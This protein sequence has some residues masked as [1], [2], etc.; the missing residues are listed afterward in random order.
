VHVED[1]G[2]AFLA[3]LLAPREA[4]HNQA[5]NVGRSSEN[6]RVSELADMVREV[7]PGSQVEYAPG[8]GPDP[9]SYRVD[10]TKLEETLPGFQPRWTVRAGIEQL[11]G[12]FKTHGLS[13]ADI[14]GG[15]Y[16]RRGVSH[17]RAVGPPWRTRLAGRRAASPL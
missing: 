13:Q 16:L 2:R 10:C 9:R 6:Y 4:V 7:I 15:R 3:V 17:P 1:I 8:G 12:A 5:F 14:T 11:Y